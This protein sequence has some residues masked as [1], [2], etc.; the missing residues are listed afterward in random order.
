MGSW[1]FSSNRCDKRVE[2]WLGASG[3][4]HLVRHGGEG[5]SQGRRHRKRR[6]R[7]PEALLRGECQFILPQP[8][9]AAFGLT[10]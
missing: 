7:A 1:H 6:L 4:C 10:R 5:G 2:P 8:Y 9:P 3:A